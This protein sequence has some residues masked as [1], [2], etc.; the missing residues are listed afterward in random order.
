MH[1]KSKTSLAPPNNCYCLLCCCFFFFLVLLFLRCNRSASVWPHHALNTKIFAYDVE[2]KL[3]GTVGFSPRII[4]FIFIIILLIFF[5]F[6]FFLIMFYVC[7]TSFVNI[8]TNN[9]NELVPVTAMTARNVAAETLKTILIAFY[10]QQCNAYILILYAKQLLLLSL[11]FSNSYATLI[12]R[13]Y[14]WTHLR[15]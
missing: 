2:R 10:Y 8:Y 7:L 6:F 15:Q 11:L 1:E 14:S 3:H 12:S 13:S 9:C 4:C 5:S